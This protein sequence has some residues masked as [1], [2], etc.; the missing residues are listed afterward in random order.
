MDVAKQVVGALNRKSS[1]AKAVAREAS[2]GLFA[3]STEDSDAS[4]QKDYGWQKVPDIISIY[5]EVGRPQLLPSNEHSPLR[6]AVPA[7]PSAKSPPDGPPSHGNNGGTRPAYGEGVAV[8]GVAKQ[9]VDAFNHAGPAVTK[10]MPA[11]ALHA[12]LQ[13]ATGVGDD[14]GAPLYYEDEV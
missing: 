5:E 13:P 8:A 1:T 4:V 7:T 9:F 11:G 14:G 12:P 3:P 2:E 10:A 6:V